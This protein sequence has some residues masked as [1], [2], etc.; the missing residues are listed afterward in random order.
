[1]IDLTQVYFLPVS[2]L[3]AMRRDL[4]SE[5]LVERQRN[6]PRWVV[7]QNPN[8]VPYPQSSLSFLGNVLNHKAESFYHRHGVGEIEPAAE[9]GLELQGRKVMTTK[10]CIKYELGGCPH[11][12]RPTKFDEPLYLLDEDG[13]RLRLAFNCRDCLMEVYFERAGR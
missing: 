7:E 4:V 12:E 13:L 2:T 6:Y 11:Q 9:S 5:I 3:N 10:H 8:D 1:M